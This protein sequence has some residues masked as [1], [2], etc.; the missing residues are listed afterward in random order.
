VF[1]FAPA[2]LDKDPRKPFGFS[3]SFVALFMFLL[4]LF[5]EE[6]GGFQPALNGGLGCTREASQNNR[7]LDY[8]SHVL[9]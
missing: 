1:P 5:N 4:S 3:R 9:I 2:F 8:V 6:G 7:G